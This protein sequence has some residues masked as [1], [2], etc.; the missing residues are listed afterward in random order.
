MALVGLKIQM[1]VKSIEKIKSYKMI[2]NLLKSVYSFGIAKRHTALFYKCFKLAPLHFLPFLSG[3]TDMPDNIK[4]TL[5]LAQ[6]TD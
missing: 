5:K 1:K 6:T 2:L 3:W 4:E